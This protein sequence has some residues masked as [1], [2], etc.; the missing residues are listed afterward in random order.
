MNLVRTNMKYD[1]FIGNIF[2]FLMPFYLIL[3]FFSNKM[4][5]KEA[6]QVLIHNLFKNYRTK[7]QI[8]K[9]I[10]YTRESFNEVEEIKETKQNIT[11]KNITEKN[12]SEKNISEKNNT[13]EALKNVTNHKSLEILKNKRKIRWRTDSSNNLKDAKVPERTVSI[14]I[15]KSDN[16]FN[17]DP[18]NLKANKHAEEK[19]YLEEVFKRINEI[20][21]KYDWFKNYFMKCTKKKEKYLL[22]EKYFECAESLINYYLDISIYFK[23]MIE[24]D[25]MKSLHFDSQ[26]RLLLNYCSDCDFSFKTQE[27]IIQLLND[28]YNRNSIIDVKL[29]NELSDIIKKSRQDQMTDKIVELIEN[30]NIFTD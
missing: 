26:Q 8:I 25:L 13:L 23:K 7:N 3:I 27:K 19:L 14:T 10:K 4:D 2:S 28:I 11:E 9:K 17:N 24:V 5:S 12:I 21:F 18:F 22:R 30:N 6:K 1:Q 15:R 20:E 16:S 29:E